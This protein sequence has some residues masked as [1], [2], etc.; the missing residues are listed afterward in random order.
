MTTT[1]ALLID[2]DGV[3]RHHHALG[4]G[5]PD[6]ALLA[7]AFRP[8][9]V[10]LAITGEITQKEWESRIADELQKRYLA[11]DVARAID[12]F[13][14][15]GYID[16]EVMA[17]VDA[18]RPHAT[19]CLVSNATDRL[20]RDLVA[21]GSTDRFDHVV[22][23]ADIGIAKPDERIFAAAARLAGIPAERCLMVDDTPANTEA[24]QSLGMSGHVFRTASELKE[25][26]DDWLARDLMDRTMPEVRDREAV[27]VLCLDQQDRLL[28]LHWRD[29]VSGA[30]LWEPTGGGVEPGESYIAAAHREVLEETG[31]LNVH[32]SPDS[33]P[34][35]RDQPWRGRR[36]RNVEQFFVARIPD[37]QAITTP[38]LTDTEVE[39]LVG[40]RWWTW[41]ELLRTTERIEPVDIVHVL[42]TLA[43][44]GPWSDPFKTGM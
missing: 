34:V 42:R 36:F 6:G 41:P 30:Y 19:V 14:D 13:R 31:F 25:V 32:I 23:S 27:R 35:R 21:L 4:S 33:I 15:I 38:E 29:P 26:L 7:T 16:E 37:D 17:I 5:L 11:A 12:H 2:F 44:G 1:R 40:S 22:A 24:A 28:L 8:E 9:L 3:L 10:N 20:H 39:T 18:A 43:P